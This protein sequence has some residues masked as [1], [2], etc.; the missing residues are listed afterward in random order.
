MAYIW[1]II[2]CLK[3]SETHRQN[4]GSSWRVLDSTLCRHHLI[5]E[6]TKYIMHSWSN[7]WGTL[8]VPTK[9]IWQHLLQV[10]KTFLQL[11]EQWFSHSSTFCHGM[12][13]ADPT[14]FIKNYWAVQPHPRSQQL[15]KWLKKE[16]SHHRGI[17]G[18]SCK[19]DE[20]QWAND[21]WM[22][23]EIKQ[24]DMVMLNFWPPQFMVFERLQKDW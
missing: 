5:K 19:K 13:T 2:V 3:K 21:T 20:E 10:P 17:F 9:R 12:P 4:P 8:L 15:C 6:K 18:Q 7:S 1:V 14:K 16:N 22:P 23:L 24:V 11:F